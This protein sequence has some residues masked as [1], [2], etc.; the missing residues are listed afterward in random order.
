MEK[1]ISAVGFTLNQEKSDLIEKKLARI[2]YAD[3]LI[4][5]LTLKIKHD[6][7]FDF[8]ATANF[9]WGVQAHVSSND[10]DFA[11][12]LNKLMDVL[13]NKIKKEKDKHQEK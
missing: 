4:V 3:E 7:E 8:E 12:G 6:K 1:S 10:E 13:D 2:S 11:A 5:N 9:R